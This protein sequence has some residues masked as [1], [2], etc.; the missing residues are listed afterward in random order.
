MRYKIITYFLTIKTDF[1]Y[2]WRNLFACNKTEYPSSPQL[3]K[4]ITI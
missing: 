3:V 1:N 2:A 4:L